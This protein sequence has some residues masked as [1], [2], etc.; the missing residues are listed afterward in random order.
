MTTF[1]RCASQDMA[2]SLEESDA[3]LPAVP[4][5]A[6]DVPMIILLAWSVNLEKSQVL[7]KLH[8]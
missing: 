8:A 4:L 6:L 5:I 2:S 1:A 7:Q 3:L